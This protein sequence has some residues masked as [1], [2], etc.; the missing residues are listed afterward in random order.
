LRTIIANGKGHMPKFAA[1][2]KPE[3]IDRLVDEISA[4]NKK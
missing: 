4:A 3:Q 1:K 2:L